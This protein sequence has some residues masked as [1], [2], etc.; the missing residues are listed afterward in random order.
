MGKNKSDLFSLAVL[1]GLSAVLP[2]HKVGA[3]LR[4]L[5]DRNLNRI[6]P[7]AIILGL[8]CAVNISGCT[9]LTREPPCILA[10]DCAELTAVNKVIDPMN[11]EGDEPFYRGFLGV[12]INSEA[13]GGCGKTNVIAMQQGSLME[14]I[15]AALPICGYN[16]GYWA[17]GSEEY[18]HDFTIAHSYNVS[19][20]NGII[21]YLEAIELTYFI[22]GVINTVDRTISFSPTDKL[23]YQLEKAL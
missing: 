2:A 16:L 15:A 13:S 9:Q 18:I 23:S 1:Y 4:I 14:N 8:C 3:F 20:P 7:W 5:V 6:F 17:I 19:I 21:S 22:Q 11:Y 12:E 10:E